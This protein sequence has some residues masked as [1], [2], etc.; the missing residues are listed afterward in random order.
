MATRSATLNVMIRAADKAARVLKRDFGEVENLQVSRKGPADFVTAADLK[1]ER[2]LRQELTKA[3]PGYGTLFEESGA[4]SGQDGERRRWIVDP[5]DGTSNFLHG[6]PHFAISIALE[7]AGDILA[8]VVYDPIKDDLFYAEKGQGAYLNDRRVRVSSRQHLNMALI[9]TGIPFKGRDEHPEYLAELAAIMA[10]TAGRAPLG[11]RFARSCLRCRRTL[12]RI[13]GAWIAGLGYSCRH[14]AGP[15]GRRIRYQPVRATNRPRRRLGSGRQRRPSRSDSRPPG[16][17]GG[18]RDMTLT[19]RTRKVRRSAAASW[20]ALIVLGLTPANAQQA[21]SSAVTINLDVLYN[22]DQ[23]PLPGQGQRPELLPAPGQA[24]RSRLLVA[25]AVEPQPE[26]T[27]APT[28]S[29]QNFFA[30]TPS[31][32]EPEPPV[33]PSP[34]A[35]TTD[36]APRRHPFSLAGTATA[37]SGPRPWR[38]PR[39][40]QRSTA[41]RPL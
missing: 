22:L 28:P 39:D 24:P 13:L 3:R 25:P 15:R 1:A 35:E 17:S 27:A 23:E 19:Q 38:R 31:P 21:D 5:L 41:P 9:A 20:L 26:V 16:N 37:A 30:A 18:D 4:T 2:I 33:E 6:L 11:N 40:R 36:P 7:D 14:P 10:N 32:S 12:R 29:A 34:V 8:A